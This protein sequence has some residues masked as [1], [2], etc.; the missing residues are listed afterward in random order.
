MACVLTNYAYNILTFDSSQGSAFQY[1][2]ILVKSYIVQ[3]QLISSKSQNG[4]SNTTRGGGWINQMIHSNNKYRP[5]IYKL[6]LK[7]EKKKKKKKINA[8]TQSIK[9]KCIVSEF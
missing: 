5:V 3:K 6:T 1:T 8:M 7:G 2:H 9:K 4:Y